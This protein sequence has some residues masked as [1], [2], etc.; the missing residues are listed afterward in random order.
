[1]SRSVTNNRSNP[2]KRKLHGPVEDGGFATISSSTSPAVTAGNT[3]RVESTSPLKVALVLKVAFI[4]LLA[5]ASHLFLT[6]LAKSALRKFATFFYADEKAKETKSDPSYVPSSAKKLRIVLQAMPEVQESQGFKALR[7]KLTADL[8]KFRSMITKEY[9]LKVGD[10]IVNAKRT[11]YHT[12]ICKW[13]QGLAQAFLA[14]QGIKNYSKGIAIINLIA[15][16]QDNILVPLGMTTK[17][18]SCLQSG[19]QSTGHPHSDS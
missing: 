6:P 18:P 8:E 9:V 12:A 17:N 4:K 7:N 19:K 11:Q 3:I 16:H 1:M 14:Q 5:I 2:S 13:M 15:K 10:M